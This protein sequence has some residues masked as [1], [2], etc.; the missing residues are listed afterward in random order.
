MSSATDP[1][2][3]EDVGRPGSDIFFGVVAVE[4]PWVLR[5]LN[6]V[7]F[8]FGLLLHRV[9]SP[10]VMGAV[11]FLCVLPIGILMRV[12]RKDLLSLRRDAT[13]DSYWIVRDPYGPDPET[14]KRQF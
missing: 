14:M 6:Y 3:P 1:R 9:V 11:F 7:W 13:R 2:M 8:R 4:V 5:P 10:L 12:A